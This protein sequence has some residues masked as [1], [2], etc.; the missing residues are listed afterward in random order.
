[1]NKTRRIPHTHAQTS[2][3]TDVHMYTHTHALAVRTS[4]HVHTNSRTPMRT[5]APPTNCETSSFQLRQ[6][7]VDGGG[8]GGG[9]CGGG[10]VVG[11]RMVLVRQ[12]GVIGAF[13]RRDER[14]KSTGG[15][16]SVSFLTN[17]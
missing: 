2:T 10:G 3:C 13:E 12:K 4:I 5:R 9:W 17:E 1:M 11:D 14:E 8:G 6:K 7:I 15:R 16:W